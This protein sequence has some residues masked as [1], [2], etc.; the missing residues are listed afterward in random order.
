MKIGSFYSIYKMQLN[1]IN[2]NKI[3][4]NNGQILYLTMYRGLQQENPITISVIN[5]GIYANNIRNIKKI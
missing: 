4:I 1:F 2:N 5:K 3:I